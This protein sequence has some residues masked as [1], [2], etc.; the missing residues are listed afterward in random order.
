ME[1]NVAKDG[2]KSRKG[3]MGTGARG[4]P[5]PEVGTEIEDQTPGVSHAGVTSE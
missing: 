3:E 1:M 4:A 5:I 2:T